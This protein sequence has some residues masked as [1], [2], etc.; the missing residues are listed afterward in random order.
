MDLRVSCCWVS[1]I[2]C[3]LFFGSVIR[4][5]LDWLTFISWG[6][7]SDENLDLVRV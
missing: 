4:N 2:Y 5:Y 1:F 7:Y 3:G 6:K